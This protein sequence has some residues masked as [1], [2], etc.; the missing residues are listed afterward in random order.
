MTQEEI[1]ARLRRA[2]D[3]KFKE[4]NAKVVNSN[5][6]MLGVRAPV[7]HTLAKEI[8]LEPED[9]LDTYLTNN[10]EQIL[11]YSLVLAYVKMPYEEK[12]PYLDRIMRL[13]D[14]W[15]HVDMTVGAF[16]QLG[17]NRDDFLQR[18]AHLADGKPFERR[19]LIVFLMAYCMTED[20]LPTVFSYYEKMQCDHHYVNMGIAWGLSVALVKCYDQTLAY[21]KD[22]P[23]NDFI[24]NKTV[25]KARES[26]RISRERKAEILK[27]KR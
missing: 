26:Y 13:Y 22:A 23:Y 5:L 12:L 25:Q 21:L 11:L 24:I 1:D 27:L 10:Y 4:F 19:F 16:K 2:S 8:A 6:P 15:A 7:L 9:F 18:Y 3:K 20:M 17:E 14:N